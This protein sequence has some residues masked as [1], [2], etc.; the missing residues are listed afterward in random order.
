MFLL[1]AIGARWRED[2]PSRSENRVVQTAA[3]SRRSGRDWT[4]ALVSAALAALVWPVAYAALSPP[5]GQPGP[6]AINL[7]PA[8]GWQPVPP[9]A[10]WR[11]ITQKPSLERI[12]YFE[13][14]GE[15][16]GVQ[17]SVYRDQSEGA[18]LVS[19]NNQ[20][21]DDNPEATARV[22]K[23]RT[24]APDA[25]ADAPAYRETLLQSDRRL[26]VRDWYWLGDHTST[27][28]VAA[29]ISLAQDRLLRRDD[30]SAWVLVFTPVHERT[31]EADARLDA[32]QREMG[33]S[34]A[35]ALEGLRR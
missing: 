20:L 35:A 23:Q 34:I 19:W 18:E 26:A 29:K 22:L 2:Q 12:D 3:A 14:A 1:F 24:V 27:S 16:V 4:V 5:F 15:I 9:A 33:P 32:F 6:T 7:Q 21:V 13:K 11:A 10:Q 17:L 25:R 28:D 31:E 30:T 8:A